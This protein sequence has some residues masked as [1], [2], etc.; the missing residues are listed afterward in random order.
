VRDV[1]LA[2]TATRADGTATVRS[3]TST[4]VP[5]VIAPGALA[6]ARVGFG[7]AQPAP[8]DEVKVTVRKSRAGGSTSTPVTVRET[9]LSRP[10]EGAVAQ[11][12]TVT[13]AN[14]RERAVKARGRLGLTCFGEAGIPV[15]TVTS[16]V[17]EQ[18]VAAGGTTTTVVDLPELCP[19]YLVGLSNDG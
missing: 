10:M 7:K 14:D 3:R 18:R 19:S 15:L 4:V 1:R 11:Q 16:R 2:A 13:L 5:S 12:L 6:V 17:P 9:T 8:D